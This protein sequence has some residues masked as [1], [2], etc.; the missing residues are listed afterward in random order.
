MCSQVFVSQVIVSFGTHYYEHNVNFLP[1]GNGESP[2]FVFD[3]PERETLK[4]SLLL[5]LMI[6][7]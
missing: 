1:Q 6:F 3:L 2:F 4:K 7:K 5:N